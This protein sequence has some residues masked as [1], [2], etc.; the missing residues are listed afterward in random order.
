MC[1]LR[2]FIRENEQSWHRHQCSMKPKSAR[3]SHRRNHWSR[4]AQSSLF[5]VVHLRWFA[6]RGDCRVDRCRCCNM[7]RRRPTR[8]LTWSASDEGIEGSY[9]DPVGAR[10][11]GARLFLKNMPI[12]IRANLSSHPNGMVESSTTLRCLCFSRKSIRSGGDQ[13]VFA[14]GKT[15]V[16]NTPQRKGGWHEN[17]SKTDGTSRAWY[18]DH[19]T[20][21]GSSPYR[22]DGCI[23]WRRVARPLNWSEIG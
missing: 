8:N 23:L 2:I 10:P 12:G 4:R 18:A 19:P 13:N 11:Q 16:C 22:Y 20:I 17:H 9:G 7:E 21:N 6:R 3:V 15:D 5:R 14:V 1:R